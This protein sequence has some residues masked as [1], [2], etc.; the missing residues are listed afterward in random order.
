MIAGCV[1]ESHKSKTNG[2][3]LLS[4]SRSWPCSR[5]CNAM[6]QMKPVIRFVLIVA[7]V[8]IAAG[9]VLREEEELHLLSSVVA[10]LTNDRREHTAV[11]SGVANSPAELRHEAVE[12]ESLRA[13]V[14]QLRHKLVE[15][16]ARVASFD[17]SAGGSPIHSASVGPEADS[18]QTVGDS[19]GRS[20]N[21]SLVILKAKSLAESSPEEA[22]RWVAALPPG[23]EQD[24]AALAVINRWI[25]SDPV[26]A[27]AWVARF[28]EG[29]L[30]ERAMSVIARQ[31]GL[32]DWNATAGW[33]EK[34]P[35]GPSR[36]AA[37]G[38]FVT[39]ADGHDIKLALEWANRMEVP[40][41][42]CIR[43]EET[44]RRWLH[45]DHAAARAWLEKAQL[46]S[47]VRERL[48]SANSVSQRR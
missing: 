36:D 37:I 15:L 47:G 41:I 21:A 40:E 10:E 12:I 2:G 42:R 39:S 7:G 23:K 9:V 24:A 8:V 46:P 30:R 26:A 34:L 14:S 44:A 31:W 25:R 18:F 32:R 4:R 45:E 3:G 35:M 1:D 22:A 6:S 33:L 13:E 11:L 29:T 16:S 27:A 20:G 28:A 5:F 19:I 17:K 48:L 43:V 38:A